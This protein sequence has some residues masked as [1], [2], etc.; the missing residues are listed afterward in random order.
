MMLPLWALFAIA[1]ANLVGTI[2]VLLFML[3]AASDSRETWF[4]RL[5]Y[6]FAFAVGGCLMGAVFTWL[7]FRKQAP[8]LDRRGA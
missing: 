6:A 8:R 1:V 4:V 5:T 7:V 2:V 3:E